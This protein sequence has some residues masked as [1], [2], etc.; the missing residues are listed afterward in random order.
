G[1]VAA[2][3]RD[4]AGDALASGRDVLALS[5][6]GAADG[7]HLPADLLLRGN[8][9]VGAARGGRDRAARGATPP[10][11]A[12]RQRGAGPY[13]ARG[14]LAE[15]PHE[16]P[17]GGR[18]LLEDAPAVRARSRRTRRPPRASGRDG[19]ARPALAVPGQRRVLARRLR[20]L[21]SAAPPPGR[22]GRARRVR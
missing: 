2:I 7:G 3:F 10:R 20:R 4:S 16:I 19:G 14:L 8:G 9:R 5:R 12:R 18:T 15:L 22:Q 11:W 21:L 13:A 1:L 17:R 6:R